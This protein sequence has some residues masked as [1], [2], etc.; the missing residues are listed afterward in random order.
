MKPSE[1]INRTY[2]LK[3]M[4]VDISLA[5]RTLQVP[6]TVCLELTS[7]PQVILSCE[8]NSSDADAT[9]ELRTM[10]EINVGLNSGI[11]VRTKVG[12]RWE[13][14]GGKMR[15]ALMVKP[16]PVTVVDKN[17]PLARCKFALLNFPNVW[18][19]KDVQNRKSA[20][21]K[22]ANY[23]FPRFQLEAHPWF[24]DIIA[25][26]GL[27]GVHYSMTRRGG[28]ALT[29]VGTVTRC[30]GQD[31]SSGELERFLEALHLFLSFVR[32]SYCGLTLLSGYDS[33]RTRVWE[34]WGTYRV[35]PW[36]RELPTW[37]DQSNSHLLTDVFEGLWRLLSNPG[38]GDALVEVI[39]WY[40]RSSE[41]IEP[42]VSVILNQAA[43]ERLAFNTVGPKPR[44]TREGEW[45]HNA[46]DGRGI[47][48]RMPNECRELRQLQP[49]HNWAH[50]PH[51]LVEIRNDLIH[52]NTKRGPFSVSALEE[53]RS[54]GLYY[55]ELMV[56]ELSGH[57]G[58][59]LNRLK[60]AQ[61]YS[62]KLETVP[63]AT[64]AHSVI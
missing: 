24:V 38:I 34:Q 25:T 63:W 46:L 23:I 60:Y 11:G 58:Q 28:S 35:E 59:F 53:A 51:A 8:F 5:K 1:R 21:G 15:N 62:S 33:N 64:S 2:D 37:A 50:G 44:S 9:N 30:D 41:S 12:D 22:W 54:L 17:R 32:T 43:L 7:M 3:R 19:A 10:Q 31:F 20:K 52:S 57:K 45:I 6:V 39:H 48:T 42:E 14:G 47:N 56:L 40:L 26:D 4:S 61:S 49:I 36:R 29:H 18:G 16:E 27:M 13:L 55:V